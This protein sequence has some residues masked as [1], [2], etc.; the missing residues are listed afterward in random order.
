[1]LTWM[2]G[3]LDEADISQDCLDIIVI[4]KEKQDISYCCRSGI[5]EFRTDISISSD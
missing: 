3:S 4:G 2:V 1:M 5:Q